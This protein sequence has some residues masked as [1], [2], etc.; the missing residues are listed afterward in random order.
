M[1]P[2]WLTLL[3]QT[4]SNVFMTFAWYAHLNLWLVI[5]AGVNTHRTAGTALFGT[6]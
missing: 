4:C 3:L 5:V 1:R 2:L 6:R